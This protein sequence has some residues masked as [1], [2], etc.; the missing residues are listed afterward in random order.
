MQ[1][2]LLE[3]GLDLLIFGMGTVLV[4]LLLLV[5]AINAMSRLIATYFPEPEALSTQPPRPSATASPVD[6]TTL[7]IIKAAIAQHRATRTRK[8]D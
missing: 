5:V 1:Q 6:D 2:T 8:P 3:Q 7:A 4:F